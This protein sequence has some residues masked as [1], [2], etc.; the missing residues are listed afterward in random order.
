[1]QNCISNTYFNDSTGQRMKFPIKDFVQYLWQN[2]LKTADLAI[3]TK[4][5]IKGKL[6]F[7]CSIAGNARITETWFNF[8]FYVKDVFSLFIFEVDYVLKIE[9][10]LA[11]S[12]TEIKHK[13]KTLPRRQL[14][15][16]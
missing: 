7:L 4:E 5:I 16:S 3:F 11:L 13:T 14:I 2:P 10:F 6:H 1:M 9:C 15:F 8:S 12:W